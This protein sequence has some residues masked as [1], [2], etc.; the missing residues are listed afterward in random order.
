MIS[1]PTCAVEKLRLERACRICVELGWDEPVCC[2]ADIQTVRA[3]ADALLR[4][5]GY[6]TGMSRRLSCFDMSR[7]SVPDWMADTI[8]GFDGRIVRA[9]GRTWS[10]GES[11]IDDAFNNEGSFRWVSD[12]LKVGGRPWRQA[13]QKRILPRLR[14]IAVS[15]EIA[16]L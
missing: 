2:R 12:F 14:L 13:P 16:S 1:T 11:E 6:V 8:H 3:P 7:R 4:D 5:I 9:D 10:I 15:L